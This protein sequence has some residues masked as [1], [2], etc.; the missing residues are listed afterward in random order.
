MIILRFFFPDDNEYCYIVGFSDE[1]N[2]K[3]LYEQHAIKTCHEFGFSSNPTSNESNICGT[4]RLTYVRLAR[5]Q[6]NSP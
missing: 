1:Q 5:A 3:L 2:W 6:K 4:R